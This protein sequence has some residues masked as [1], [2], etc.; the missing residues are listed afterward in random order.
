MSIFELLSSV[1]LGLIFGIAAIGIYLTF[2]VIDFPDLTCDG[3]FVLGA[4]V[5]AAMLQAGANP[6]LALCMA[7]IMGGLAGLLTGILHAYF[8]VSNLL[9]GILTA[10]MLYSINLKVMGGSPNIALINLP[11]VFTNYN[12]ISIL[13]LCSVVIWLAVSFLL[14][15]DLGLALR[16]VGLNK[17]LALNC[18]IHTT[19]MTIFALV[20]SNGLIGISG[21]LFSQQQGFADVSQGLGTIIIGLAAVML[22]EKLLPTRS[23]YFAVAACLFGS[24]LYRILVA[25]ALHSEWLGLQT[26][27]LNIITGLLIVGIMITPA[28]RIGSFKRNA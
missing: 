15:T 18:G 1:E 4:A 10:F 22:G 26:Q 20:L 11:S 24:V 6:W 8:K 14:T 9:S 21:A 19:A 13:L 23:L 28:M 2:R 5:S 12:T 7:A 16:S 17:R 3:S 27:D 25:F